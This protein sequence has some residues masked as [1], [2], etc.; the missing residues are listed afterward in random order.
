[1]LVLN[2][3]YDSSD[4]DSYSSCLNGNSSTVEGKTE[5]PIS[6]AIHGIWRVLAEQADFQ[7]FRFHRESSQESN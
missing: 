7:E 5:S 1:M 2:N 3:K 6:S 4:F